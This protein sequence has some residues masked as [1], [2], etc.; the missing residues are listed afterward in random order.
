LALISGIFVVAVVYMTINV[1]Y[2]VV[3]DLDAIRDTDAIAAV[4][5]FLPPLR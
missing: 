4:R 2:F 1:S 5:S 3:L